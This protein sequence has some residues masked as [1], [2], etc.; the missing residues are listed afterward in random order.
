MFQHPNSWLTPPGVEVER[1]MTDNGSG[2]R[3]SLFN[4]W[5]EA[6]GIEHRYA[7]PYSSWQNGKVERMNRTLAQEW[8]YA[9]AYASEGERA[10]APL[11]PFIDRYN[12]TRPH[13]ACGGL[14]PMSRIVGVNN[15]MAHNS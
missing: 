11:P 10:A 13:S 7:R 2:Y 3:S 12:W 8:Q 1:V 9:R 4:D 5:L 14:P 6:A 15:V